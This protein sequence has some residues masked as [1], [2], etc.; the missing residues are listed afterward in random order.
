MHSRSARL[1]VPSFTIVLFVAIG[2]VAPLAPASATDVPQSVIVSDNPSGFTPHVLDGHINALL[3]VGNRIVAAGLFTQVQAS[4]GGA[5]LT[6]NN[7]F[8]FDATS[9]TID[10]TFVPNI[11]GEVNALA[12]GPD[13]G[14]FVGGTFS[15]VNGVTARRLA[16]LNAISGQLVTAFASEPSGAVRDLEVRGQT[17]YVGGAFVTIKNL[18]RQN[19][20]A[21]DATT[22]AVSA[23]LN[24]PLTDS[25]KA[26]VNPTL[27]KFEVSPDGTKM[28]VIGNFTKINGLTRWQAGMIDLSTIPASVSNWS[29]DRFTPPCAIGAF[30]TYMRDVAFAPDGSYFVIVTTGAYSA[31]TLCDA[32]SRWPTTATG[33]SLQPT[34]IDYTGGDTLYSVAV[35]GTAI[36]VGGHQRWMNNPF[37][38]DRAGPGAV[39]REGIAALDPVNGL[40]FSWN[41]GRTRGVGV[42][43]MVATSVGLWVGSDTD[44]I[45]GETHRKLAFF[46]TAGGTSVPSTAPYTLPGTLYNVQTDLPP[47]PAP[48]PIGFLTRRSFDGT[49]LG[50]ST[51]LATPG[52][53]WRGLRGMFALQ[54]VLYY[55]TSGG[56]LFARTFNGTAVGPA[57]QLDLHGLTN[58]P[59]A[60]ITGM[61]YANGG[62]YYTVN[63]DAQMYFRYFTPE[64]RV[65]G[66]ERFVVSG[67]GDGLNWSTT[68]GLTLANG[69]IYFSRTNN[70][71]SS[72]TFGGTAPV[73][74]TESLV[75][76]ASAGTNWASGGLFV[77]SATASDT[78][79]PT[80]PGQPTG[81]SPVAGSISISW[82]GSTDTSPPI[83]YRIYRDGGQ[84]VIGSTTNTSFT[85]SGL[86]AGTSHTYRV[87]AT[88]AIGNVSQMSVASAPITVSSSASAIFSDDF[89]AGFA[90]WS[91]VTNLAI[92]NASGGVAPP[93]ARGQLTSQAGFAFKTLTGS[94]NNVCMSTRVN[95]TSIG[96]PTVVVFRLRT[97]A[98]GNVVRVYA[99]QAGV[100]YVKSDVDG[101]QKWSGVTMGTGWHTVELCGAVGATSTWDLYRDGLVIVSDWASNTGTTDVGRVEIGDTT[102]KTWT[103]NFDDVVVDQT[104]G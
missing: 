30:D 48:G 2:L 59:I 31:G 19:L 9:G 47:A 64:S 18:P 88:D 75:S 61:F 53:D 60:S 50:G 90:N 22:G 33:T 28:V 95:I 25:R 92:D 103:V 101:T 37:A 76:P 45:G 81:Q 73:P 16:K 39:P 85:D 36:Y 80:V 20:A 12:L 65:V 11:N 21:V 7:I 94:F 102:A 70:D 29:T 71:L 93:S 10:T 44:Q 91:G 40:P 69:K 13:G 84:T 4:G 62:I 82:A 49:T 52:I 56:G 77:F 5:T 98:N 46:P 104:P 14:I 74:G 72:M 3:P 54:G 79:P 38:G 27:Y 35:T 99:N 42:F 89:S 96:S 66:A 6:R 41:P 83:T 68:R 86:T 34:W 63:N 15:T 32:T 87:D 78:T 23:N 17:L 51:N 43:D 57:Q 26:G 97:A 1:L 8:A 58:F 24:L 100:L 67:N 55:G